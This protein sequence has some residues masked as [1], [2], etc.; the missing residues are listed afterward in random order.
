MLVLARAPTSSGHACRWRHAETSQTDSA[1]FVQHQLLAS[2]VDLPLRRRQEKEVLLVLKRAAARSIAGP[3]S[4]VLEFLHCLSQMTSWHLTPKSSI[5]ESRELIVIRNS[6]L[7]SAVIESEV[8]CPPTSGKSSEPL[9]FDEE[10]VNQGRV[11]SKTR[12]QEAH[13]N[14][15]R[16][17]RTESMYCNWLRMGDELRECGFIK[18][19]KANWDSRL[20]RGCRA[21]SGDIPCTDM[22]TTE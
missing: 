12:R 7:W 19:C 10:L 20:E 5:P 4:E 9:Q 3:A 2:F 8:S 11:M 15:V 21:Q 1:T 6:D 13:R 16:R 14:I 18:L 17:E 22:A